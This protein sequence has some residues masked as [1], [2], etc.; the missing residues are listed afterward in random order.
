[1]GRGRGY[2]RK[3][4]MRHGMSLGLGLHVVTRVGFGGA[5]GE[6]VFK[7]TGIWGNVGC[8]AGLVVVG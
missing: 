6:R 7:E 3:A 8:V 2:W 5:E 4:G 1:M